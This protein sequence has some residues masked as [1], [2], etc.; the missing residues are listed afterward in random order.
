MGDTQPI[1]PF[2]DDDEF[3]F[4]DTDNKKRRSPSHY[5][6]PTANAKSTACFAPTT[7]AKPPGQ[8]ILA[9]LAGVGSAGTS[10][11]SV[12][13]QIPTMPKPSQSMLRANSGTTVGR[14]RATGS[15][16]VHDLTGGDRSGA[17]AQPTPGGRQ[18]SSL[19]PFTNT[20]PLVGKTQQQQQRRAQSSYGLPPPTKRVPPRAANPPAIIP[21]LS[22]TSALVV[23]PIAPYDGVPLAPPGGNGCASCSTSARAFQRGQPQQ[24]RGPTPH[25]AEWNES[26]SA[27]VRA[28]AMCRAVC[29]AAITPVAAARRARGPRAGRGASAAVWR[30]GRCLLVSGARESAAARGGVSGCDCDV[31]N[32]SARACASSTATATA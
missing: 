31:P 7:S 29:T 13:R 2:E 20:P 11:A 23:G 16:Q 9:Q 12:A 26:A 17:G 10:R 14:P 6:Q 22:P 21:I 19:R 1:K 30:Q 15:D 5:A 24:P 32:R 3:A 8:G 28:R 18:Q 25:R 27:S 4:N